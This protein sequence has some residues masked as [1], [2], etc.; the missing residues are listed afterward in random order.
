MGMGRG[1]CAAHVRGLGIDHGWMKEV[2]VRQLNLPATSI[3]CRGA[4][5]PPH[6]AQS[7]SGCFKTN[8]RWQEESRVPLL[9]SKKIG[10]IRCSLRAWNAGTLANRSFYGR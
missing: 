2:K 8:D 5:P 6:A 9:Q 3:W 10:C 4:A 1:H 7:L